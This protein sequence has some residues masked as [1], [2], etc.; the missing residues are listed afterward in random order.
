MR[1]ILIS[2]I[3]I[4][5]ACDAQQVRPEESKRD[6]I[7]EDIIVRYD[8]ADAAILRGVDLP[9]G[10]S[11]YFTSGL[12]APV[13]DE[14]AAPGSYGRYG[15]TQEQ[16]LAILERI[17]ENLLEAGYG[18]ED[19][20]FLRIYLAPDQEGKIDWQAWFSAYGEYFNNDQNPNK[21]A[22]S[23]I[24]VYALAHPELLV[25]IEAVAAK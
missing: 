21:V 10:K 14:N 16:S 15:N 9:P 17:K 2:L 25:E 12:V 6:D 5:S 3:I 11:F 19:V 22:R 8:R 18:M 1:A 23:T 20:F 7:P 13:K 4:F 24:G